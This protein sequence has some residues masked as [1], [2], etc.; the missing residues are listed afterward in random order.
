MYVCA[1]LAVDS[2]RDSI[3]DVSE[4]AD[5]QAARTEA[6]QEDVS[7]TSVNAASFRDFTDL[8]SRQL[9]HGLR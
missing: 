3:G 6:R 4:A 1:L 5:G 8:H 7:Y 9:I 2:C